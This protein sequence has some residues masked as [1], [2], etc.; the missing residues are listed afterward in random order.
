MTTLLAGLAVR[1]GVR[2][3]ASCTLL[4]VWFVIAVT[5][6]DAYRH[7]HTSAWPQTL[8]WLAGS[9]L[10]I[11]FTTIV[12]LARGRKAQPT[13]GILPGD[14][15]PMQLAQASHPLR[16]APCRRS[17]KTLVRHGRKMHG[18]IFADGTQVVGR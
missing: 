8:A 16:G 17:G 3:F 15:T 12:W 13:S 4:N 9:A 7:I 11:A 1:F 5:L 2:R 14:T 18:M 6:P 10:M